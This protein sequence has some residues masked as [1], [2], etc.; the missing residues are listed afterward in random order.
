M[1]F[2]SVPLGILLL[3]HPKRIESKNM[4]NNLSENQLEVLTKTL[5]QLSSQ[6]VPHLHCV[7]GMWIS[8]PLHYHRGTPGLKTVQVANICQ[9][10]LMLLL[11]LVLKN[12]N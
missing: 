1:V 3:K 10:S 2:L 12:E 4:D 7:A 9:K 6:L 5:V 11:I 8:L